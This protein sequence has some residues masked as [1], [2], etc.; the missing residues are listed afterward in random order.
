MLVDG[1]AT[2][3]LMLYSIFRKLGKSAEDLCPTNMGLIDFS[4]NISV[5]KGVV[6]V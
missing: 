1:G 6:C 5:T 4:G 3:N 2:V